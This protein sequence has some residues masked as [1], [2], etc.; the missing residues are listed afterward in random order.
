MAFSRRGKG[1]WKPCSLLDAKTLVWLALIG[2]GR[3]GRRKDAGGRLPSLLSSARWL[4]RLASHSRPRS[5]KAEENAG[6]GGEQ[7]REQLVNGGG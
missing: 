1:T 2:A 7:L 3:S 5:V 6:Q 4:E